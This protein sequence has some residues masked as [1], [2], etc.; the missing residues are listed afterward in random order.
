AVYAGE[1]GTIMHAQLTLGGGMIMLGS[2]LDT[3]FGKLVKQPEEIGGSS[4][5]G[6]Y[7][8]VPGADSVYGRA[9]GHGAQIGMDIG[10]QDYGGRGFTCRD[11]EGHLWSIGTYDPWSESEL[12][13]GRDPHRKRAGH[14]RD[15]G[16]AQAM[17]A[18]EHADRPARAHRGRATGDRPAH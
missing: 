13:H 14:L 17:G 4:T 5:Q 16:H 6:L 7:L 18:Q 3:P 11:P 2:V 10:H 15:R 9:K 1:G 12:C 8:V